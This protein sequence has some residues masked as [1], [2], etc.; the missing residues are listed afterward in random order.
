MAG[1][2]DYGITSGRNCDVL[3]ALYSS[4]EKHKKELPAGI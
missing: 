4:R 3:G 1:Q 2:L